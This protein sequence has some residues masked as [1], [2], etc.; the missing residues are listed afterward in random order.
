M[1]NPI[2][3][4][5]RKNNTNSMPQIMNILGAKNPDELFNN[6]INTNPQ[7]KRFVEENK[8]RTPEEI[9]KAY[10]LD[11]SILNKF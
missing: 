3:R 5:L 11:P 8:G 6:M 1:E 7:F 2:T 10:G 9:A 4:M